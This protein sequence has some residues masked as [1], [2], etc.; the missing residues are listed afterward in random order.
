MLNFNNQSFIPVEEYFMLNTYR[1]VHFYINFGLCTYFRFL[2][3]IIWI[4]F[5][6]VQLQQQQYNDLSFSLKDGTQSGK[7]S[8]VEKYETQIVGTKP[9]MN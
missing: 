6:N 5:R 7:V 1:E 9:S 4:R 2:H 3:E 8:P